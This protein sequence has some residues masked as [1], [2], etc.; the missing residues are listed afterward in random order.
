MQIGCLKTGLNIT[1]QSNFKDRIAVGDPNYTRFENVN[2]RYYRRKYCKYTK[3][4]FLYFLC[5]IRKFSILKL[6]DLKRRKIYKIFDAEDEGMLLPFEDDKLKR[7]KF[8]RFKAYGVRI[9]DG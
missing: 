1:L 6:F 5:T 8:N 4:L 3:V 2:F 7:L 9:S